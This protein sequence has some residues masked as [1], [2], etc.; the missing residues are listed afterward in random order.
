MT[1]LQNTITMK[2]SLP[3]DEEIR[4]DNSFDLNVTKSMAIASIIC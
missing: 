1:L 2:F 3:N 4:V